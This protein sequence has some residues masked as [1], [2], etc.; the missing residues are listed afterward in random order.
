MRTK[1]IKEYDGS[2]SY[3]TPEE[4]AYGI[5][6]SDE[7]EYIYECPCG[8]GTI[9]EYHDNT[10]GFRDHGVWINCEDCKTKYI[11]DITNGVR[12]WELLSHD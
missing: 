6:G 7:E 5:S 4:I 9:V 10:V 1:L 11:I 2:V 8:K 3:Q 12:K